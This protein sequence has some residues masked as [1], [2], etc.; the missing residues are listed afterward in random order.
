MTTFAE[1][2]QKLIRILGDE[3]DATSTSTVAG[4]D[5]GADILS[6]AIRAALDA[7][8]P[9]SYKTATATLAGSGQTYTLP[10]GF[11]RVISVWD[12]ESETF[13]EPAILAPGEPGTSIAGNGWYLVP[14]NSISFYNALSTD[15]GSLYY[16]A[17]WGFPTSETGNIESPEYALSGLLM[18]AASYCLLAKG[19]LASSIRQYATKIDAG[20]PTDNPVADMSTFFMKRFELEMSRLP[21]YEQ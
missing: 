10:T 1:A 17:R 4:I 2:K 5:H 15:G 21:R 20:R 19:S 8:L 6:D 13:L 7:I 12:G 11:Y 14:T 16:A 18:Y 3:I 9:W